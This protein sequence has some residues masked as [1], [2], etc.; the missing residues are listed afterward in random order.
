MAEQNEP[1]TGDEGVI[2][3]MVC[4]DGSKHAETAFKFYVQQFHKPENKVIF[5]HVAK[6]VMHSHV[7]TGAM[8]VVL[9]EVPT[10]DEVEK[11]KKRAKELKEKF[12]KFCE[13]LGVPK[14]E[15]VTIME[16]EG[17]LGAT[18]VAAAKRRSVSSI[19]CGC[20]GLGAI[21]RTILGSVSDYVLHH[22]HV[23]TLICP[24]ET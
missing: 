18:I 20:R 19:I 2:K 9:P 3:I 22:S 10:K 14:H 7:Y 1:A 11:E 15:F 24:K 16:G 23:P 17:G 13:E 12:H 5:M 8:G 4:V 6:L 21:R